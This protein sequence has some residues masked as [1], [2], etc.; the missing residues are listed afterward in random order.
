MKLLTVLIRLFDPE[1][2]KIITRHLDTISITE[3]T[4]DVYFLVWMKD[5][6]N[7]I[8]HLKNY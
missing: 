2:G 1:N 6:L 8:Y 4:P 5:F 3:L 7:T